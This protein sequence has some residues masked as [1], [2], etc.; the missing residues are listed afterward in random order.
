MSHY[1]SV[2]HVPLL[3]GCECGQ[4][5]GACLVVNLEEALAKIKGGIPLGPTDAVSDVVDV[6]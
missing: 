1:H 2:E 5:S 3:V 6:G 4:T